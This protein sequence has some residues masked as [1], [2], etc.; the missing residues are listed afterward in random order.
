[1]TK[2]ITSLALA[3][4]MLCSIFAFSVNALTLGSGEYGIIV[5]SDAV[6]GQ[7]SGN[8]TVTLAYQYPSGTD[9]DSFKMAVSNTVLAFNNAKYQYVSTDWVL[10]NS[11]GVQ[12][13]KA[14][15]ANDITSSVKAKFTTEDGTHGWNEVRMFQQTYDTVSQNEIK[16]TTGYPITL[17]ANNQ[18]VY[19]KIT[20]K[21]LATLTA[22]DVIGIPRCTVDT[23][24]NTNFK[25]YSSGVKSIETSKI[26]TTEGIAAPKSAAKPITFVKTQAQWVGGDNTQPNWNLGIVGTFKTSDIA[27]AFDEGGTSTNVTEVGVKVDTGDYKTTETTRF[28]YDNGDGTYSFRAVVT[29]IPYDVAADKTITVTFFAMVKPS[30]DA[31][32]VKVTGET[33][34]INLADEFAAAQSRTP[35]MPAYAG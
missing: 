14:N 1:M 23:M 28:V 4:I 16:A 21:V 17:D 18:M 13:M 35:A 5:T 27:I 7:S 24:K 32:P 12:F 22:D 31:D 25:Y 11:E 34:T 19:C 29:N 15:S 20:F 2:K 10:T 30:A 3:L 6:V 33:K 26:I 9:A 8:I